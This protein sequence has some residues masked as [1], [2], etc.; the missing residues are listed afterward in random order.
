MSGD[1]YRGRCE[2]RALSSRD[3]GMAADALV[4]GDF[5]WRDWW[6]DKPSK[7]YLRAW[8]DEVMRRDQDDL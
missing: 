2:A 7:E 4:L 8:S 6:I 3:V 5:D 1:A